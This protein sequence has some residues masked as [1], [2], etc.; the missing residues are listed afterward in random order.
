MEQTGQ[1]VSTDGKSTQL[2]AANYPIQHQKKC[3][4]YYFLTLQDIDAI[5]APP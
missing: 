3:G 1:E 5:K 2:Q 4:I